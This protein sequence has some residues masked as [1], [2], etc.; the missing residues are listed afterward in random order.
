MTII[1]S[2]SIQP[3]PASEPAS[4]PLGFG[5]LDGL[6]RGDEVTCHCKDFGR[7]RTSI[8]EFLHKFLHDELVG[9]GSYRTSSDNK[10]ALTH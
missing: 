1:E 3:A 4:M 10:K 2:A 5:S 6:V 9:T 7:A 8:L